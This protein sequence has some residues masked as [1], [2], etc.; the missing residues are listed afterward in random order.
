MHMEEKKRQPLFTNKQLAALIIPIIIE[1]TLAVTVGMAD[2]MMV[3][4]A[5][6]EAVSGIALVNQMNM[7]LIQVFSAMAAGGTVV[8]SQF[9]GRRDYPQAKSTAIQLLWFVFA[10]AFMLAAV[11]LTL[12]QPILQL[13]YGHIEP[14][15]M[16]AARTYFYLTAVSFPFLAV[17]NVSASLF[18]VM[19]NSKISMYTS[20]VM[21]VINIIGNA[22]FI[23]GLHI[24]VLGAG[25]AT[26][27][28][29]AAAAVFITMLLLKKSC[30]VS[31]WGFWKPKFSRKI[32]LAIT[33]MGVPNG[34]EGG[35]FQIG[36]LL[37]SRLVSSFGTAS[38]TANAIAGNL[39]SM[40][41]LPAQSIGISMLT[42]VGQSVGARDREN[43]KRYTYR[44]LGLSYA[45][46]NLMSLVIF[47]LKPVLIGMYGMS[48]EIN[49]MTNMVINYYILTAAFFWPLSFALPNALRGAGDARFTM[50]VSMTSMW[51]CRIVA[52]H[53]LGGWLGLGLLG[54]YMGMS[55]DWLV[56]GT[57]FLLRV[58][59]KKWLNRRV[60]D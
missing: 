56:R 43:A 35:M 39:D 29:R 57:C 44:L 13:I 10:I 37:V 38:I 40:I 47:L 5:G 7:L 20:L 17:Y 6:E 52:A 3:A 55:L 1:Q 4:G 54:V 8:V 12:N 34:I 33:R 46:L 19:G 36:K 42:V 25:L 26:L 11:T 60:I 48:D 45:G 59:G 27:L 24:G 14:D 49:G 22:V 18:R 51:L 53:I 41:T 2:T 23:F 21:N 50:I 31:I 15:V 9:L 16:A 30:P 32:L 58:H 28:S